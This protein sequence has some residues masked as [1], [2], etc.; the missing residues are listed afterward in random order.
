[1]SLSVQK[2]ICFQERIDLMTLNDTTETV[3]IEI[4][5]ANFGTPKN[6]LIGVIH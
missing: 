3:F 4:E 2:T 1:M 5:K 6:V